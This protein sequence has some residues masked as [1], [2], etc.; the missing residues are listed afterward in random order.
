[1]ELIEEWKEDYF[2][3]FTFRG[4]GSGQRHRGRPF[5]SRSFALVHSFEHI[6]VRPSEQGNGRLQIALEVASP[7]ILDF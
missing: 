1:M 6:L 2:P 7:K 3:M 5:F 4:L